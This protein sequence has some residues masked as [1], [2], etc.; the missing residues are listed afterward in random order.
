MHQAQG[1][2]TDPDSGEV[3]SCRGGEV[4]LPPARCIAGRTP[5]ELGIQTERNGRWPLPISRSRTPRPLSRQGTAGEPERVPA[6]RPALRSRTET[7]Q[8]GSFRPESS[9][10]L[11]RPVAALDVCGRAGRQLGKQALELTFDFQVTHCGIPLKCSLGAQHTK[12][13]SE[14][15]RIFCGQ[16]R[17]CS[18]QKRPRGVRLD[19]LPRR[20]QC[21]ERAHRF[22]WEAWHLASS[23]LEILFASAASPHL[24]VVVVNP[25]HC[26]RWVHRRAQ[27]AFDVT[28][29]AISVNRPESARS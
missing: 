8:N 10:Q 28:R 9:D 27:K 5:K 4:R 22:S 20:P 3:L 7:A 16:C 26:R 2:A 23:G 29:W 14:A 24:Q 11:I 19:S 21:P 12:D 15:G 18:G 1:L 13:C 25:V 6:G 17:T